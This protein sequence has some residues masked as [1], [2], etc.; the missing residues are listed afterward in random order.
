MGALAGHKIQV[1]KFIIPHQALVKTDF[2]PFFLLTGE[3]ELILKRSVEIPP[4]LPIRIFFEI[5]VRFCQRKFFQPE[6]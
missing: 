5:T 4:W 2:H 3:L 1:L 6:C